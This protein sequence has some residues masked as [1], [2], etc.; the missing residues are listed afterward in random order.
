MPGC[1]SANCKTLG[2]VALYAQEVA[3]E[4]QD[5]II[6][7]KEQIQALTAAASE[8]KRSLNE[9]EKEKEKEEVS[10]CTYVEPAPNHRRHVY[11]VT[12]ADW[13]SIDAAA[14]PPPPHKLDPP[15]TRLINHLARFELKDANIP[16]Q[17]RVK[18]VEIIDA[19]TCV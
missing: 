15:S 18:T 4:R 11:L 16:K 7:L 3:K 6:Q 12:K 14:Y 2:N 5:T 9:K 10:I 17:Y 1:T 8:N 19:S 13:E